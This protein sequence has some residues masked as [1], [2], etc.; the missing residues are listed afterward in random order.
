MSVEQYQRTL[1]LLDKDIADL[2]GKKATV[3][4]KI[5]E[6]KIKIEKASDQARKTKIA[7]TVK[8]KLNQ[9]SGWEKDLAK[10]TK[11][12]SDYGKKISDKRKKRNEAYLKLQKEEKQE[13]KKKEKAIKEMQASYESRID[14]LFNQVK[15]PLEKNNSFYQESDETYDVFVSHAWEDKEAFVDEF[16]LEMQR[17]GMKVWYGKE[18]IGWGDSMRAKIDEGLKKSK[19]GIAVISPNY[20]ASEKYWTKAELDGLFQLESVNGKF[21]LPIWFN[22]TKQQIIEYSP[23]IAN[24]KALSTAMMTINEIAVEMKKLLEG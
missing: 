3:D 12:S 2:E 11:D 14:E 17:L 18:K 5:A 8:S 10:K 9:I 15:A 13:G 21:L 16:V 24:R 1:N 6:L 4:I 23:I 19:F 22:I 20:I 7:S